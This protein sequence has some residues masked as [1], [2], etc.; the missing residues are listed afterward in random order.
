[1][2]GSVIFFLFPLAMAYAAASDLFTY[3][4]ANWISLALLAGFAVAAAILGLPLA[5]LG[6]HLLAGAGVL[7]AGF[8]LFA[9]GWIGGGD[10][11]LTAATALWL[12]P[13]GLVP[14]IVYAGI[15]GGVLSLLIV[16]VR[17]QPLP[18]PM[19]RVGWI[20]RLTDKTNGVP[21]G[22]ALAAAAI[23]VYPDTVWKGLLGG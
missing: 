19:L 13:A 4:I 16:V 20:S 3:T 11:K 1:V 7:A 15:F 18:A 21:Y 17:F 5:D 10:A 14:Y 2:T 8:A 23:V 12:G 9:I 6:Y 22:V